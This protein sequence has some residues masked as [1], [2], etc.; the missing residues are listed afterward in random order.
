MAWHG[1]VLQIGFNLDHDS[2][3][4]TLGG[5]SP[6]VRWDSNELSVGAGWFDVQ[7]GI[8]ATVNDFETVPDTY[9]WGEARR[10]F[11]PNNSN[12]KLNSERESAIAIRGDVHANHCETVDLDL[13]INARDNTLGLRLL[14]SAYVRSKSLVLDR[15]LASTRL[16]S[17]LGLP[18]RLTIN[19]EY[20]PHSG[21]P[22]AVLGYTVRSTSVRVEAQNRRLTLSQADRINYRF[23]PTLDARK[24]QLSVSVVREEFASARNLGGGGTVAATWIP[25]DSVSVKWADGNWE[26]TVTAPLEGL[27]GC[28][29]RDVHLSVTAPLEGLLGCRARDVH[30]SVRQSVGVSLY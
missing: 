19:P 6:R 16:D 2:T 3:T 17:P 22:D 10:I 12:S 14:G 25:N 28:R 26:A 18:G 21:T 11:R 30:L 5:A 29:A 1:V 23:V 20:D 8:D 9:L 4:G 13:R 27:L 24:K 15:I 7:G